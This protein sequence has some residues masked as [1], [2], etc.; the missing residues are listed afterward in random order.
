MVSKQGHC[1]R[2]EQWCVSRTTLISENDDGQSPSVNIIRTSLVSH[3]P[4]LI[5]HC[6]YLKV[7]TLRLILLLSFILSSKWNIYQ[8]HR[9]PPLLLLSPSLMPRSVGT[10]SVHLLRIFYWLQSFSILFELIYCFT[11]F[12]RLQ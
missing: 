12:H 8:H 5:L 3:L 1:A 7:R 2:S 4:E 9:S 6:N 11:Y 10:A